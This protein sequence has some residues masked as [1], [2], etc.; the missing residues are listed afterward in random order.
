LPEKRTTLAQFP[1]LDQAARAVYEVMSSGIIPGALE[2]IDA[3]S[4]RHINR[5]KSWNWEEVPTLIFEF[6]G[7]PSGIGEEVEITRQICSDLKTIKYDVAE[8]KI[9][10]D[11]LWTGRKEIT[12]A[13]KALYPDHIMLRGDIAV[14]LSKFVNTIQKAQALGEQYSLA[15]NLFGHA[16]DGNVHWHTLIPPRDAVALKNGEHAAAELIHFALTVGGTAT[17]EHG[18]G[19]AKRRFLLEEHGSA[20]EVMQRIK[21]TLDPNN[22]LNPGKI[23][24]HK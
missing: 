15:I 20:V 17:A 14:P 22:I 1:Q 5:Y 4:I 21:Q 9:I 23:F 2:L 3:N 19:L 10:R 7:T 13:E 6:H 16:G 18:I 24:L 11:Q 12:N 8:T